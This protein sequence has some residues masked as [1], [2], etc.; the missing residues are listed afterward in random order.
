MTETLFFRIISSFSSFSPPSQ[1]PNKEKYSF[2]ILS[3]FSHLFAIQKKRNS[4]APFEFSHYFRPTNPN[5][6]NTQAKR[7]FRILSPFPHNFAIIKKETAKRLSNFR[8]FSPN[9]YTS[10]QASLF[11][12]FV[13][14][15]V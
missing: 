12:I 2:R 1:T 4:A 3:S 8:K 14:L 15:D 6:E 9:Q 11:E 5:K 7:S 13:S 10:N